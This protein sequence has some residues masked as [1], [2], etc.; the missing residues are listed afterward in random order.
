VEAGKIGD[1]GSRDGVRG[2]GLSADTGGRRAGSLVRRGQRSAVRSYPEVWS[3][4]IEMDGIRPG[5]SQQT[6]GK[7]YNLDAGAKAIAS[8]MLEKC[9]YV[10]W[11]GV[12]FYLPRSAFP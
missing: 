6:V 4:V 2:Q 5:A 1:V 12:C 7:L 11:H 10:F 9:H 3:P 8:N